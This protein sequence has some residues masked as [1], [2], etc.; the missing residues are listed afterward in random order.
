MQKLLMYV[1]TKEQKS[2]VAAAVSRRVFELSKDGNG[3]HVIVHCI[4][5]FSYD[6]N[7]VFYIFIF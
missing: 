2:M 4:K 5:N 1:T 3:H 6:L 7:Q